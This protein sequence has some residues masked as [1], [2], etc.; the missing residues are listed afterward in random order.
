MLVPRNILYLPSKLGHVLYFYNSI[1]SLGCFYSSS[2]ILS[3]GRISPSR[4]LVRFKERKRNS[5][6]VCYVNKWHFSDIDNIYKSFTRLN[7]RHFDLFHSTLWYAYYNSSII[8][9]SMC[10]FHLNLKICV[11]STKKGCPFYDK[12]IFRSNSISYLKM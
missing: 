12:L 6:F 10:N 5:L 1:I 8:L 4:H 7:I 2:T 11:Q 3:Q 9:F